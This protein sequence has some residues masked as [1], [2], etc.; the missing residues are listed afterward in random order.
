MVGGKHNPDYCSNNSN[1]EI[2][3]Y[4]QEP[5]RTILP[6]SSK[7]HFAFSRRK[8]IS[9]FWGLIKITW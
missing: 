3:S 2:D 8:E 1:N 9:L 4:W 5:N 7:K 6:S